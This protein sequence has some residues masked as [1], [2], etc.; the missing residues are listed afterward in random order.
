MIPKEPKISKQAAASITR[1]ITFMIPETIEIIRK[2]GSA[3][4]QSII[5]VA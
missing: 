2:L 1:H 4:S 3:T 5:M